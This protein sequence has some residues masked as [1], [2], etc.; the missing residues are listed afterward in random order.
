[1]R[2]IIVHV[3]GGGD[4]DQQKVELRTGLDQFLRSLKDRAAVRKVSLRF[5]FE[6]SRTATR[7]AFMAK[8]RTAPADELHVLLVDSEEPPPLQSSVTLGEPKS[9]TEDRLKQDAVARIMHLEK[10]PND[11]WDLKGVD[12]RTVHLIGCCLE[13]LFCADP[14]ALA[15]FYGKNFHANKLPDRVKLEEEPKGSLYKK[16]AA[17]TKDSTKGAYSESNNAK[18]QHASKLLTKINLAKVRKKCP[19]FDTFVTWLEEEIS[20]A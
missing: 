11:K 15:E 4:S 17:A 16:L 18:I 7:D 8:T 6:G 9:Q 14:E 13:T 1:M 19:H 2:K 12:P 10:R 20:K 3:E 5:V